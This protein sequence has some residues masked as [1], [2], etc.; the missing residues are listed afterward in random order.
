MPLHIRLRGAFSMLACRSTHLRSSTRCGRPA[1]KP[2]RRS[3]LSLAR[4][5]R[6]TTDSARRSTSKHKP[7]IKWILLRG[8]TDGDRPHRRAGISLRAQRQDDGA[9]EPYFVFCHCAEVRV[10]NLIDAG[11]RKIVVVN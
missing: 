3:E 11:L 7:A 1:R 6:T 9:G 2:A 5:T 10:L 8:R 4:L